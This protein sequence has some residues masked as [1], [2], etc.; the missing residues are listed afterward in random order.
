MRYKQN[1]KQTEKGEAK[2]KKKKK[3]VKETINDL[4]K[5]VMEHAQLLTPEKLSLLLSR[6][7]ECSVYDDEY[8]F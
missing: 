2:K 4:G 1:K 5:Y 8:I 7:T 6:I 3:K